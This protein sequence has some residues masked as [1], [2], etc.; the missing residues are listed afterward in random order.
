M[1]ADKDNYMHAF[2]KNVNMYVNEKDITIKQIAEKADIPYKTLDTFLYNDSMDCKLSTAVK[3]AR[4]LDVSI[5][6]LIGAETISEISRESIAICRNLPENSV[7]LIRWFIRHQKRLQKEYAQKCKKLISVMKPYYAHG[8]L[9][10]T[11]E[12]VPLNIDDF[13]NEIKAKVF[14]GIQITCEHYMPHYSPYDILLLANDRNAKLNEHC[15]ILYYGKLFIA[16]RSE[17][18][19]HEKKTVQYTFIRNNKLVVTE[20]E[21][22]ELIGYVVDVYH[23]ADFIN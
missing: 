1:I 22:D 3:L 15:V 11:N 23:H 2:K 7:Y 5:D 21:I 13:S 14:I 19:I 20:D 10:P 4:A 16:T 12:F 9:N 6:E 17:V 8:H 18:T